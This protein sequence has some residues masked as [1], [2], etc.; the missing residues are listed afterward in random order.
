MEVNRIEIYVKKRKCSTVN[1][2]NKKAWGSEGGV[3]PGNHELL[4]ADLTH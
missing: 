4:S 2:H 1:K 3:S